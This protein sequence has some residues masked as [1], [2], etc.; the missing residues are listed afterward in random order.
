[1]PDT[2]C[3]LKT[4]APIGLTNNKIGSLSEKIL[5][6]YKAWVLELDLVGNPIMDTLEIKR[7][8][9]ETKLWKIRMK[10]KKRQKLNQN[11]N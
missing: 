2:I 11:N 7:N 10:E 8:L 5:K 9:Y 4:W 1:M 6:Y 3:N